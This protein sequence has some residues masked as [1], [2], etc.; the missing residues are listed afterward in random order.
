M[1][2]LTI[3]VINILRITGLTKAAVLILFIFLGM[4]LE[5]IGIILIIPILSFFINSDSISDL[6]IIN[7]LQ[8]YINL[9]N[10]DNKVSFL[11]I[12][13]IVVFLF[14]NIFLYFVTFYK[15]FFLN[16]LQ[17][18]LSEKLFNYYIN[19]NYSYHLKKNSAYLN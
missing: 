13:I 11:I 14:K 16:K 10:Y 2:N 17:V 7:K 5:L 12:L 19:V 3:K 9:Y 6:I 4:L 18:T 15:Y 1:L 8:S